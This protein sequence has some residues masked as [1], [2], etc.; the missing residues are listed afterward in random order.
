MKILGKTQ[1]SNC[2]TELKWAHDG[3]T[4]LSSVLYERV[5]VDNYIKLFKVGSG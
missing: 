2:A 3:L 4:V 5:K 1:K